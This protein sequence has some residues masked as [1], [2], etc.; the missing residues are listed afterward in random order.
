MF[1]K[2]A[3]ISVNSRIKFFVKTNSLLLQEIKQ[4]I[5]VFNPIK[6]NPMSSNNHEPQTETLAETENF[7]VWKAEEPDGEVTYYLQ[8]D[9]A[10]IHFFQEEWD[11]FLDFIKTIDEVAPDENGLYMMEFGNIDAWMDADDWAEFKKLAKE[12]ER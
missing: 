10:T 9:R 3:Q 8:L 5:T 2:F 11:E 12:L 7:F 6:E 1:K 4:K